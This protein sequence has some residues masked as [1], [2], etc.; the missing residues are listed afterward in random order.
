M[1]PRRSYAGI[2]GD[3]GPGFFEHL[4]TEENLLTGAYT[5]T[6]WAALAGTSISFIHIPSLAERRTAEAGYLSRQAM[7][8]LFRALRP[9]LN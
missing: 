4:T 6:R 8:Y 2:P 9:D 3:G 1:A 7:L 5:R